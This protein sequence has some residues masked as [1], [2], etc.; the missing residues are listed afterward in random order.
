MDEVEI[1]TNK[2]DES[3]GFADKIYYLHFNLVKGYIT[4]YNQK[5][6]TKLE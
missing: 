4:L 3:I 1:P 6:N 5:Y 2:R